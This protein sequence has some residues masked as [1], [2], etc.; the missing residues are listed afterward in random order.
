[1]R[2]QLKTVKKILRHALIYSNVWWFSYRISG[3]GQTKR[4][5]ICSC[6]IKS[7]ASRSPKR[8]H[9]QIAGNPSRISV[10]NQCGNMLV[11]IANHY[12]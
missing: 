3:Q 10:L 9:F 7:P 8:R 4:V 2:N 5:N 1:M 6:W 11:A 12:G